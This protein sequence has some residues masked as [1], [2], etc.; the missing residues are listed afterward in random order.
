MTDKQQLEKQYIK[1]S[2]VVLGFGLLIGFVFGVMTAI[3]FIC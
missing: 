3:Y 2:Y 1:H